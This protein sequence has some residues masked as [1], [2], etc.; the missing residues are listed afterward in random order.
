MNGAHADSD[1]AIAT[2]TPQAFCTDGFDGRSGQV[3]L[4]RVAQTL[5]LVIFLAVTPAGTVVEAS[6]RLHQGSQ[7][8]PL[9][10]AP[11]Q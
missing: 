3:A 2:D 7:G 6:R 1:T 4:G 5:R 10:G 9:K 8:I 11:T